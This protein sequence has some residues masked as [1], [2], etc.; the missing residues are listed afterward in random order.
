M[1]AQL[2]CGPGRKGDRVSPDIGRV[3]PSPVGDDGP[4]FAVHISSPGGTPLPPLSPDFLAKF[5]FSN[6]MRAGRRRNVLF[7]LWLRV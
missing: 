3:A 4:A 7:R 2:H 1:S 5:A 6:R